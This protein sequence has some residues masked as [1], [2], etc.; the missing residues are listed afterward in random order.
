[1]LTKTQPLPS[2]S[3]KKKIFTKTQS[4]LSDDKSSEAFNHSRIRPTHRSISRSKYVSQYI[5]VGAPPWES[6]VSESFLVMERE[7]GK[8]RI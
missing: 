5:Y 6:Q 2:R 4:L 8:G 3:L 1:M 7:K